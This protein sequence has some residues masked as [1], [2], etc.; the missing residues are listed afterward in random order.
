MHNRTKSELFP[1]N[2]STHKIVPGPG[3]HENKE[4]INAKGKYYV[5]N[6]RNSKAKTFNPSHSQRFSKSTTD[7]P[8]P[9]NYKPKHDLP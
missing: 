6:H 8:G 7:F 9:G 1:Q 4:V 5:S 3:S 2:E